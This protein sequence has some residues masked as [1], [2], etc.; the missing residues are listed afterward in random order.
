[1]Q[2]LEALKVVISQSFSSYIC[3]YFQAFLSRPFQI[4]EGSQGKNKIF[5]FDYTRKQNPILP[6]LRSQNRSAD[7]LLGED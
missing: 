4:P 2:K 3:E 5:A 7:C 6:P 1:M